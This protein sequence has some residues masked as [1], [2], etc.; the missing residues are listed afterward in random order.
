MSFVIRPYTPAD[1]NCL[2]ELIRLN[3]PGYFALP[4]EAEYKTYLEKELEDY[5]VAESNGMIIGGGGINY[6]PTSHEARISWDMVHPS[7]HGKGIGKQLTLHRIDIIKT[8][9]SIRTI[10]VRTSQLAYQFYEKIGFV[11]DKIEK[12]FW[13]KGFD[14]CLMRMVVRK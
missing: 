3:T 6:F 13:A 2:L 5:F 7:F 12:D 9:P 10:V 8:D 14:L 1:K 11:L 4:E